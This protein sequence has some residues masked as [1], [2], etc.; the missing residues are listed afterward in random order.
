[1]LYYQALLPI[2]LRFGI[3]IFDD[4]FLPHNLVDVFELLWRC[5]SGHAT[6]NHLDSRLLAPLGSA[7]DITWVRCADLQAYL[8]ELDVLIFGS[9]W[10]VL[11]TP[12][13]RSIS[14]RHLVVIAVTA[15]RRI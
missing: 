11:D 5:C 1:M 3:G 12:L 14:A 13:T 4:F 8:E 6:G 10:L 9:T 7:F 15:G 2:C